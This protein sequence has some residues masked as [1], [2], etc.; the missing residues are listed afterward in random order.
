MATKKTAPAEGPV[1]ETY[2]PEATYAVRL[3]R[4]VKVGAMT[5]YA[6]DEHTMKGAFLIRLIEQHGED[7]V[8]DATLAG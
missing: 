7:A 6:L 1:A 2:E 3:R 5:L 8:D 4:T